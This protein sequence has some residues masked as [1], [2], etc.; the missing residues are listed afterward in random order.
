M[1]V[2]IA[3]GHGK[4]AQQVV[5]A[6][7]PRGDVGVGLVRHPDHVP[8]LEALGGQAVVLDLESAG[9]DELAAHLEGADAV[10][11]AAGAGPDSGPERKDTVDRA[12][13]VLL[14]DAA[15]AA[16]VRRFVQISSFGAGE[17]VP[18]GT[19]ESF[20]VYLAAKTAAEDD[21]RARDGLDWTILRPG[22][23]TDDAGTGT[24]ALTAPPLERGSVPREDV[25]AVVVALLDAPATAGQVLMLTEGPTPVVEAVAALG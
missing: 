16:G 22:G 18:E 15:E 3:G 19:S 13:S 6:L 10:L 1:R 20:T 12:G 23:L 24:V 14:A 2:V 21:L 25:A 5:K 8:E 17:E 7:V 9:V 4:I 11:F